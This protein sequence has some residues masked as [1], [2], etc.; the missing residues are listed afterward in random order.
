MSSLVFR[1]LLQLQEEQA[2]TFTFQK[3]LPSKIIFLIVAIQRESEP[4]NSSQTNLARQ[5]LF[6]FVAPL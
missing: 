1:N 2:S 4:E 3:Y 5:A 6:Q